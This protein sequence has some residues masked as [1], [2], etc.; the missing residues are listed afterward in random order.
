MAKSVVSRVDARC[1]RDGRDGIPYFPFSRTENPLLGPADAVRQ[2]NLCH[3]KGC[4]SLP[5][6]GAQSLQL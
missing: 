2:L 4:P 6:E 5:Y 3:S 1:D